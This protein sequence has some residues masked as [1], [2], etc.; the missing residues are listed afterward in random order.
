VGLLPE[1]FAVVCSFLA[2]PHVLCSLSHVC[3]Q[4]TSSISPACFRVPLVLDGHLI[5]RLPSS[6][7][8]SFTRLTSTLSLSVVYGSEV[9]DEA[10]CSLFS[11]TSPR[12]LLHFRSLVSLTLDYT[13]TWY[14]L[15]GETPCQQLEIALL[16]SH[17]PFPHITT[18]TVH[19]I[20]HYDE[21]SVSFFDRLPSLTSLTLIDFECDRP[22]QVLHLLCIAPLEH[23]NLRG[24][25]WTG[26]GVSSTEDAST[27]RQLC[28]RTAR[29]RG[30]ELIW[31]GEH[32]QSR[33]GE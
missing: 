5:D 28:E 11:P 26:S 22:A 6:S 14:A 12:S 18:L 7:L 8:P 4:L 15:N 24:C 13:S 19:G 25:R 32:G 3:H 23:L 2:P 9:S 21:L 10:E 17:F 30:I 33:D 29:E 27:C 20:S 16:Y 31:F 1:L